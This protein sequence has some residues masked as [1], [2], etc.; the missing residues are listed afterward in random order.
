[1]FT[2]A[3]TDVTLFVP[4]VFLKVISKICGHL[5]SWSVPRP[6]LVLGLLFSSFFWQCETKVGKIMMQC[7]QCVGRKE[8]QL[9][10]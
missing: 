10:D 5:H 7:R 2:P 6:S 9:G 1:M 3:L 8:R 4:S